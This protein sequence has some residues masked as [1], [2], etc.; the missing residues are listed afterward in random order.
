MLRRYLGGMGLTGVITEATLR[1]LPIT[2]S[3]DGGRHGAGG[4]S[5]TC[6]SLL[7]EE[8]GRYRYSVAWIDG[9]ASGAP[10]GRSVLT[11]GDHARSE[12]PGPRRRATRSPTDPRQLFSGAVP[13]PVS[14]LNPLSVAAF[15]EMWFRKAP[16]R[17]IGQLEPI[18]DLL[19]PSRR[20]RP[21]ERPLRARRLHAVSVRRALRRRGGRANRARAPE[22]RPRGV[23]PRRCS[24]ASAGRVGPSLLPA[25][26]WTLALDIPLGGRARRAARRP[27]QRRRRSGRRIYWRRTVA[28]G[29]SCSRRCTP[30]RRVARRRGAARPRRRASARISAAGSAWRAPEG[31]RRGMAAMIDATGMPQ[32]AVVIGGSVRHRPRDAAHAAG[33]RL[34]G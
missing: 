34:R 2:T 26:G 3:R 4:R 31:G 29:P 24:S 33:R 19:P 15:N 5:R 6:M 7:A 21:L 10:V 1:L 20:R 27:R 17:R 14:L 9:L 13:P 22:C 32:S 8:R 18:A 23:F 25:E 12:R 11:R 30:A 28:S 16:R